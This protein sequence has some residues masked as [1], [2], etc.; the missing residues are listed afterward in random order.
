[1]AGTENQCLG[2]AESL[3]VAPIIKKIGLNQPWKTLSPWLGM[4][5]AG[6][7]SG[8]RLGPPWPDLLLASGRKSIAAARYIKRKS[9]GKTFTLQIQDPR[10]SPQ[11]FDLVAVPFHDP[12]RGPNVL[13]TDA[14]PNRVTPDKL[15]AAQ[16]EFSATL[17]ILPS[18]RIAVLIGG[19]SKHHDL[20]GHALLKILETLETLLEAGCSLMITASRRTGEE[21]LTLLK[22]TF[23]GRPNV[24][25]WDGTGPNP[26]FGFLAFA[27]AIFVTEDSTSM[28]SDAG[29]TGKP[30][31]ILELEGTS[32][33]HALFLS[34]LR[35]MGVIRTFTGKLDNWSYTPLN[36]SAKI[37]EEIRRKSGLF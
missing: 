13:V 17:G 20:S 23:Q 8:D 37:A 18:P 2:V 32:S 9:G 21:N 25:L 6:A 15:T 22:K 19:R 31:Y 34:H 26:Y 3:G 35:E 33:R 36:D 28:I 29:T 14:T 30:V 10:I 5:C 24:F 1:M 7:F 11:E 16:I 27:D 4:E 12:T